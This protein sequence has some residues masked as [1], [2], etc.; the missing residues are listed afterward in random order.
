MFVGIIL[1]GLGF[2]TVGAGAALMIVGFYE[3]HA[4]EM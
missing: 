2:V 1:M 4:G 3:I